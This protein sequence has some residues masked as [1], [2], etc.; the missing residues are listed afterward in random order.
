M[1][2]CINIYSPHND[3]KKRHVWRQI[4]EIMAKIEDELC[5]IMGDFNSVLAKSDRINCSYRNTDTENFLKFMNNNV[6]TD[7]P[8]SNGSFTWFG[9]AGKYS[10]LDR[11]LAS[12]NWFKLD[13][14]KLEGRSRKSSDHT[15]ILLSAAS[16][17]WGKKPVK[18]FNA[19]IQ[20]E[21]VHGLVRKRWAEYQT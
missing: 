10:K 18:I 2:N 9:L 6:L 8:L 17:N 13:N 21:E 5:I 4:E 3:V 19:W 15:P 20:D 11:A 7:I 12:T 16:I 14:W 1:F